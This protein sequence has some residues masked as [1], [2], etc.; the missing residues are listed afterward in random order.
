[1]TSYFYYPRLHL[2][3]I[4]MSPSR[5]I[6]KEKDVELVNILIKNEFKHHS[7]L[8]VEYTFDSNSIRKKELI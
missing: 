2:P 3:T 8:S 6:H 5:N 4:Y 7:S 1:M